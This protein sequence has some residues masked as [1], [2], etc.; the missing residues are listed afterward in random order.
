MARRRPWPVGANGYRVT[1]Y[2]LA[3]AI[4][5][6][7]DDLEKLKEYDRATIQL[8]LAHIKAHAADIQ[9]AMVLAKFGEPE[10]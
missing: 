9:R 3:G 1:A 7:A 5:D 6:I 10:E 8:A 2:D 4:R